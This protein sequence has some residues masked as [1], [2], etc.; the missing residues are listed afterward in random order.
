MLSPQVRHS[1]PT[2]PPPPGDSSSTEALGAQRGGGKPLCFEESWAGGGREACFYSLH[3]LAL[4]SGSTEH[5][6]LS[7]GSRTDSCNGL[8]PS[9]TSQRH[10]QRAVNIE[11]YLRQNPPYAACC[12]ELGKLGTHNHPD[13]AGGSS[14][15]Q[16]D[17]G[18][19]RNILK[20]AKAW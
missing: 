15:S 4:A 16:S 11:N 13:W 19:K 5:L 20:I 10:L 18:R 1:W 7:S 2:S 8:K 14:C 12:P 3:G 9:P 6:G 17:S